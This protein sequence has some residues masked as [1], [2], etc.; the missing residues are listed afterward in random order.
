MVISWTAVN[1]GKGKTLYGVYKALW[2]REFSKGN[3]YANFHIYNIENFFYT[4]IGVL[5]FDAIMNSKES[6][7]IL[8]D[9]YS[10]KNLLDGFILIIASL[11]RKK[12]IHIYFTTQYY[13]S[14]KKVIRTLAQYE[15]IPNFIKDIDVLHIKSIETEYNELRQ[16]N[17]IITE[18]Y[19]EKVSKF[20]KYYDTNEV[21]TIANERKIVTEICRISDTIYDIENNLNLFIN[22]RNDY[23]RLFKEICLVKNIDVKSF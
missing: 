18:F 23:K 9:C 19:I 13:T 20:F 1:V 14:I 21:P 12:G 2:F 8:D 11:S 7:I 3:I 17:N 4:P 15:I 6:L 10:L 16:E 5:P 22:N